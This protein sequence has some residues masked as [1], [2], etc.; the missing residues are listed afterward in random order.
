MCFT[1]CLFVVQK[2]VTHLES[3][4]ELVLR[5]MTNDVYACERDRGHVVG[6]MHFCLMWFNRV[7][8]K[9][10]HN[11]TF[12][13]LFYECINRLCG[14]LWKFIII[15]ICYMQLY[16]SYLSG[17]Y[18]CGY[19]STGLGDAQYWLLTYSMIASWS[20]QK[21]EILHTVMKYSRLICANVKLEHKSLFPVVVL[22][23]LKSG[24]VEPVYPAFFSPTCSPTTPPLSLGVSCNKKA[25][26]L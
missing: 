22:L 15:T 4:W 24:L 19:Q 3:C 16:D 12:F 17:S 14:F 1:L 13:I 10:L 26:L 11:I 6:I 25:I 9:H 7:K 23:H 21:A 20:I 2:Q 5:A 8:I 18:R